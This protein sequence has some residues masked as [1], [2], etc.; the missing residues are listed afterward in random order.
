MRESY[1]LL[2]GAVTAIN[3]ALD[4]VRAAAL[5]HVLLL[6]W[7]SGTPA[8]DAQLLSVI[9]FRRFALTSCHCRCGKRSKIFWSSSDMRGSKLSFNS[10]DSCGRS[11]ASRRLLLAQLHVG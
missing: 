3:D 10:K 9:A 7:G 4:E 5:R 11:K 2:Q 1:Q 6:L 8:L